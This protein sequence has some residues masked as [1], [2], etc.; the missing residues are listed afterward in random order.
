[1]RRDFNGEILVALFAVGVL[2]LALVFGIVLTISRT[3]ATPEPATGTVIAASTGTA[4]ASDLTATAAATITSTVQTTFTDE[5]TVETATP[6][7]A[8]TVAEQTVEATVSST[9]NTREANLVATETESATVAA[10]V[11]SR[12][13]QTATPAPTQTKTS[14]PLPPTSTATNTASVTP[15]LTPSHTLTVAPSKTIT[16]QPTYTPIPS[17]TPF[18]TF[19]PQATYTPRPSLTPRPTLTPSRTPTRT[20]T[21]SPTLSIPTLRAMTTVPATSIPTEARGGTSAPCER[22]TDWVPYIVQRGDTLFSIARQAGISVAELQR[23]NCLTTDRIFEGQVLAVPEGRPIGNPTV[24]G[25]PPGTDDVLPGINIV[26]CGD[27]AVQ[28]TAPR[29]GIT[30]RGTISI[31]GSAVIPNF[32]FYKLEIRAETATNWATF[33][34]SPIPVQ[35]GLLGQLDTSQFPSGIYWIQVT[36]IDNTSNYPILPCAIRLNFAN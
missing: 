34:S 24:T 14:T 3:V 7:I 1:M 30:V 18:P 9:N 11:T 31:F 20:L 5:P 4:V 22:Q 26:Q 12:P 23:G 8:T 33:I 15:S 25:A 27:A 36:A 28:I 13:T 10:S 35:G 21:A 32:N 29:P 19:T 2:A 16:P 6:T 17:L